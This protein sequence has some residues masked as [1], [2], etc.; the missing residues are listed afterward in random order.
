[1]A[2]SKRL[3]FEIFRRDNFQCRYCGVKPPETELR[4]DHVVPTALGG[5]TD[6]SNLVTACEACNSGK[7]SIAPDSPL[8]E[9]VAQDAARWALAM[10]AAAELRARERHERQLYADKF[11]LEWTDWT[12]G[13]RPVFLP[14][15]WEVTLYGFH[16]RGLPVEEIVP[17]IKAAMV[18]DRVSTESVF[19]YFCGICWNALRDMHEIAAGVAAQDEASSGDGA[20]HVS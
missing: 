7:T 1:M 20:A 19:R 17:A 14:D 10:R 9:D 2:V 3:R 15:D 18:N 5:R 12:R 16:D 11:I 8:V 4:A 13:G 6:S